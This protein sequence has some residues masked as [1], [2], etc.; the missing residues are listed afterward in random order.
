MKV[1]LHV[2]INDHLPN[3]EVTTRTITDKL[4]QRFKNLED[5]EQRLS[6]YMIEIADELNLAVL[7]TPGNQVYHP[8]YLFSN[9]KTVNLKQLAKTI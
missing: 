4:N 6:I 1:G 3:R 5:M 8:S 9:D 7:E 2:F